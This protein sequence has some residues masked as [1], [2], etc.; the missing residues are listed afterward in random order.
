[1][2]KIEN[3]FFSYP[4]LSIFENVNLKIEEGE[5]VTIIGQNG[6]GKSTFLNL[7]LGHLPLDQG[8]ILIN[9]HAPKEIVPNE[10]AFVSQE[11]LKHMRHFPATAKE[12]VM[13]KCKRMNKNAEQLALKS[14]DHVGMLEHADK[15]LSEL[16]GGQL[17]RA[18][19]AREILFE[20]KIL[21]LDEPTAGLDSQARETLF[22]LLRHFYTVHHMTILLV[23]HH[24]EE[25]L[26]TIYEVKDKKLLA[27]GKRDV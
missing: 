20:P 3:A 2:I 22:D 11:G 8:R 15:M 5:F 25:M 17:Q 21:I 13:L 26:G 23:T 10:I 1:M 18:L 24:D 19:I 14:L 12:L 6:S 4:N 16:S 27:R 7:L 9:G